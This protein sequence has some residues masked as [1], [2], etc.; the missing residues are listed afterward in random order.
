MPFKVFIHRLVYIIDLGVFVCLFVLRWAVNSIIPWGLFRH[1]YFYF[2]LLSLSFVFFSLPP[3]WLVSPIFPVFLIK[4]LV[5]CCSPLFLILLLLLFFFA[6]QLSHP[7]KWVPFSLCWCS[8]S[9][10]CTQIWRF[11]LGTS[12]QREHTMFV[13]LCLVYL[14]K[15][16]IFCFRPLT[17]KVHDFTSLYSWLAF[18]SVYAAH[19]HCPLVRWRTCE[20]FPFPSYVSGAAISHE[21]AEHVSV[22]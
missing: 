13:F 11:G 5:P 15:Y 4:S 20:L 19:F 7:S 12:D 1:P 3:P 6:P 14:S 17:C 2:T 16:N 22:K 21:H 8:Y 9:M 18:H 10:I